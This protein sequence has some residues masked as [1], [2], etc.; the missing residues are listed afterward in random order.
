MSIPGKLKLYTVTRVA[1]GSYIT[2]KYVAGSTSNL[3]VLA[4]I[5]PLNAKELLNLSEA[6]RTR[7]HKKMYSNSELQTVDEVN[8][9]KADTVSYRGKDFEV[10]GIDTHDEGVSDHFKYRLAE[11]NIA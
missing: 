5:Q 11:V 9:I 8:S 2:G 7:N 6:Q 1:A 4:N 10:Q 3:S